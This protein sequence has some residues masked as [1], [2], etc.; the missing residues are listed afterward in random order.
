M[1]N[2]NNPNGR[3]GKTPAA[4]PTVQ[5]AAE[6]KPQPIPE[7][8]PEPVEEPVAEPVAE[9]VE[10]PVEQPDVTE[11]P[12][13]SPMFTPVRPPR[14]VQPAERAAA[15][16]GKGFCVCLNMQGDE[17]LEFFFGGTRGREEAERHAAEIGATPE[18][19]RKMAVRIVGEWT[20]ARKGHDTYTQAAEHLVNAIR[21]KWR[22]EAPAR[23]AAERRRE[24][25]RQRELRA[26]ERRREREQMYATPR[27]DMNR[28]NSMIKDFFAEHPC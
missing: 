8:I 3:R 23:E 5:A 9:P 1:G 25:E 7:P 4:S 26:E 20:S 21:Y 22:Q 28:V 2:S 12:E 13:R 17:F 10:Q 19:Y 11:E 16:A 27:V 15:S 14:A 24:A 6:P 18:Q